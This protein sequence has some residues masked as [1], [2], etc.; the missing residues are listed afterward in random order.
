MISDFCGLINECWHIIR[1]YIYVLQ[2]KLQ[3]LKQKTLEN[4]AD[5]NY[6]RITRLSTWTKTPWD[7]VRATLSFQPWLDLGCLTQ[8]EPNQTGPLHQ[9]ILGA[10]SRRAK[11]CCLHFK[12]VGK[13]SSWLELALKSRSVTELPLLLIQ[14]KLLLLLLSTVRVNFPLDRTFTKLISTLLRPVVLFTSSVKL[15]IHFY[16]HKPRPSLCWMA[17]N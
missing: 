4:S 7:T 16:F 5:T 15:R 2:I 8:H 3:T 10:F 12:L 17:G 1:Y 14:Q 9:N 6:N 11:V 13:Q